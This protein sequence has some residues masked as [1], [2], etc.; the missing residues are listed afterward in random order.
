MSSLPCGVDLRSKGGSGDGVWG[1]G[2]RRF[3]KLAQGIVGFGELERVRLVVLIIG[4]S[5]EAR[6]T[7]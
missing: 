1:A 3:T 4:I 6:T 2:G 7:F 5:N